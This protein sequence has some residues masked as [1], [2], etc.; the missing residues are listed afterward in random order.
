MNIRF[1]GFGGQGIVLAGFIFGNA[2]VKDGKNAIQNQSYGSEARGGA[3]R[4]DVII[5]KDDINELAPPNVDVLISMSH[6]AYEKYL[7]ALKKKGDIHNR[8]GPCFSH[9]RPQEKVQVPGHPGNR[10][11]LQKVRQE[12]HGKHGNDWLCDSRHR[13]R[14]QKGCKGCH[15]K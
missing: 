12:D 5:Q 1:S 14:F 6:S 2:A 11:R 13:Y 15:K 8:Y 3:C 4:S 7:H 10:Y 9:R